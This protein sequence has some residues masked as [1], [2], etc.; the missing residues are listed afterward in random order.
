MNIKHY[1]T[2]LALSCVGLGLVL[3]ISG[4]STQRTM[5]VGLVDTDRIIREN[6]KY[7]ELNVI[8]A[9]ERDAVRMQIPENFGKM[10]EKQRQ[11]VRKKL[12]KDAQERSDKFSKKYMEFLNKLTEDIRGS[13]KAI[14]DDRHFDMIIVDSPSNPTVLY[15]SGDNITTD[16]LLKLKS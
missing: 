2:I 15:N 13:A 11:E 12:V 5:K 1:C 8:L 4:C 9:G 10:D 7:M 14:A 6:P 3:G 16:I